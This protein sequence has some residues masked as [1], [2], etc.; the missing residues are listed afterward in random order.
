MIGVPDDKWG[1]AVK[2]V[3]VKRPGEEASGE[4]LI[5][6]VKERLAAFKAPKSIDFI[7]EIPKTGSG[8]IMKRAVKERYWKGEEKRVH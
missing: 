2:A 7:E 5:A 6:F 4:E 8:K 1:E 3:V